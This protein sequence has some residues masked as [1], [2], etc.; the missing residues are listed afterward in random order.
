[1]QPVA[2]QLAKRGDAILA[3]GLRGVESLVAGAQERGRRRS[4]EGIR[5]DA[6]GDPERKPS[7]R[8]TLR[9]HRPNLRSKRLRRIGARA[10]EHHDELVSTEAGCLGAFRQRPGQHVRDLLQERIAERM[11]CA[12]VDVLEVVAVDDEKA[13]RHPPILC[14]DEF[15]LEPLL[16]AAAIEDSRQRIGHRA[17]P[18]A[19]QREC[20]V[21]RRCDM[22][23]EYGSRVQELRVHML[24]V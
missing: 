7:V 24:C 17:E 15:A 8:Q 12:V 21:E 23:G 9:K 18:L 11:T 19:L 13:Q 14:R 16:E 1:M 2:R 22:C 4:V 10:G 3:G 20:G 5:R 6:R